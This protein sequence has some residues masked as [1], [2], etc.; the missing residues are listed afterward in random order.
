M[1]TKDKATEDGYNEQ[2]SS[3]PMNYVDARTSTMELLGAST[4]LLFYYHS[5]LLL[6]LVLL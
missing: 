2:L 6:I 4:I 5:L 1:G 3:E